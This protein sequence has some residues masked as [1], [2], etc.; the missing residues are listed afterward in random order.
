MAQEGSK[1]S[2]T[3]GGKARE[4]SGKGAERRGDSLLGLS[5]FTKVGMGSNALAQPGLGRTRDGM[6]GY[7]SVM[8]MS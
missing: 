2:W 4:E 5:E 8:E 6:T 1:P 3:R 7:G